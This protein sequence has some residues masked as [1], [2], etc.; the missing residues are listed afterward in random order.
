MCLSLFCSA[1]H[2]LAFFENYRIYDAIAEVQLTNAV[3]YSVCRNFVQS[4]VI[5]I[6]ITLDLFSVIS[7][8]IK[9]SVNITSLGL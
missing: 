9:V 3:V 8:I 6:I 4:S 1:W 5:I 2:N 7:R